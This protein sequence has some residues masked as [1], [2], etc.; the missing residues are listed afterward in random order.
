MPSR[1]SLH[2]LLDAARRFPV[3]LDHGTSARAA[4]SRKRRTKHVVADTRRCKACWEC[5]DACK[6]GVLGKV[7]IWFHRHVVVRHA[8]KCRGCRRCVATCP[9]GVFE[10]IVTVGRA[11]P[12]AFVP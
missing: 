7:D 11:E 10:P 1:R 5:I 9:N 3:R 4:A 8:E 6:Q 12:G 2:M